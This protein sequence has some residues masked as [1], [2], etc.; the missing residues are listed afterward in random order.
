M[1]EKKGEQKE[2]ELRGRI[3][4]LKQMRESAELLGD[5]ARE[6]RAREIEERSD[7]LQ[8]FRTRTA[9][10]LR[11]ERDALAGTI[12]EDI[13]RA[14]A[15][16]AKAKGFTLILSDQAVLYGDSAH[17][18]TDEVLQVLNERYRARR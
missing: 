8:R 4:E 5:Q 14:V 13:R 12:L 15:E 9:R 17:D 3:D 1:L 18:V 10:E 7:E 2:T 11:R 6:A 16:Y